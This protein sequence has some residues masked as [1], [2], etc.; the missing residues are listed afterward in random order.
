MNNIKTYLFSAFLLIAIVT[1]QAQNATFEWSDLS[2]NTKVGLQNPTLVFPSV[3]GFTTYTL[4]KQGTQVFAPE[5][6]FITKFNANGD[7]GKTIDFSLP[8]RALKDATL[9]KIIEGKDKLYVF[10]FIA[11]KKDKKNVLYAQVYD[12]STGIVS[13]TKEVYTLPIEK[14]NTSGFFEVQLSEDKN[15]FAILVNKPFIKKT[16][17]NI[18]VVILD[19][20]LNTISNAKH[21]LSFDSERA[22]REKLY[23]DNDAT[24]TIVKK[25]DIFKKE[26]VTSVITI[27]GDEITQQQVS[28]NQFYISDNR[29]V[30][31]KDKQ[32]LLGFATDNAKPAVSMGGA[33]DKSF[34]IYNITDQKLIKNQEWNPEIT[35]RILG[36]GFIDLKV[37]DVIVQNDDIFLIGDR[38]SEESKPIPGQN[39][40]YN[41]TYN[42]GPGVVVKLNTNGD[43]AYDSLI[44]YGE[45]YKNHMKPLGSFKPFIKDNT[46]H[47]FANEKVSIL[48]EKK[49]VFGWK[50]I[51]AK[52]IVTKK[53]ESDG[54]LSINAFKS[55]IVGGKDNVVDFAPTKTIQL[56]NNT[57]YIYALGNKYQAFGKMT[58]E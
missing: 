30:T 49:I 24:V 15:T 26:P 56:D 45:E 37:I 51:N 54:S 29:V 40:E 4:E 7:A 34:F 39:F 31:I 27:K 35:K 36:K 11:V 5:S 25:T 9:L 17:E 43:V 32:Y 18:E 13:E 33:K 21:T 52:A 58:M 16:K 48:E 8:K 2:S 28:A 57:Y 44:Q 53:L 41:Y 1:I 42:F 55:G 3:S 23:V 20:D 10:S 6:I 50:N 14:V 22:Y 38:F 19:A 47:F 46:I 12:N